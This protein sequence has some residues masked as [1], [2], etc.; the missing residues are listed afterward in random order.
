M[1]QESSAKKKV[2]PIKAIAGFFKEL[3]SEMK[4]IVWP[5][6]QQLINNTVIVIIAIVVIGAFVWIFDGLLGLGVMNI[7]GR[8]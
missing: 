2:N 6:R 7:L 8:T 1:P 4:K 3:R 5:T